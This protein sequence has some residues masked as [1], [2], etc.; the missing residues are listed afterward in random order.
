MD[1]KKYDWAEEGPKSSQETLIEPS[2]LENDRLLI[3]EGEGTLVIND[4]KTEYVIEEIPIPEVKSILKKE[5]RSVGVQA[6]GVEDENKKRLEIEVQNKTA[7]NAPAKNATDTES[8]TD[9]EKSE[10]EIGKNTLE[11]AKTEVIS[12]E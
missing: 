4:G 3:I 10:E 12:I 9:V 7:K 2:D 1:Q 8:S 11:I 6:D 5:M